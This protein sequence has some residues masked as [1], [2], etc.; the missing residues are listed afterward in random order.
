MVEIIGWMVL[1]K[2]MDIKEIVGM[3]I[4]IEGVIVLNLI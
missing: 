2:K 3:G 1:G 4:I